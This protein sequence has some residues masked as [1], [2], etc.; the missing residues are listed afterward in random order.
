MSFP[1]QNAD[2]TKKFRKKTNVKLKLSPRSNTRASG[3]AF[4]ISLAPETEWDE[5]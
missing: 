1:L 4:M 2:N 3:E 5:T